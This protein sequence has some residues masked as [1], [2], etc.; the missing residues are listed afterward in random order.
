MQFIKIPSLVEILL[1]C[2]TI[3]WIIHEVN[4]WN[5]IFLVFHHS[6]LDYAGDEFAF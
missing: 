3:A 4:S 2:D 6:R 5:S 1:I